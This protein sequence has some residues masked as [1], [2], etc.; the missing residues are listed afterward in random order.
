ME[1]LLPTLT[2]RDPPRGIEIKK[3]FRSP[4]FATLPAHIPENGLTMGPIGVMGAGLIG[5]PGFI[6]PGAGVGQTGRGWIGRVGPTGPGIGPTI[7]IGGL[8][9]GP[10]DDAAAAGTRERPRAPTAITDK[11]ILLMFAS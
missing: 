11:T 2:R 7:I 5:P 9:T 8:A 3:D 1:R 10:P 4:R 6:G